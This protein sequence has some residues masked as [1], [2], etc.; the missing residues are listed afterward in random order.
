MEREEEHHL[1]SVYHTSLLLIV[2][3]LHIMV[4]WGNE[5]ML[6]SCFPFHFVHLINAFISVLIP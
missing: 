2:D 5:T 4:P 6:Y 3:I 1:D